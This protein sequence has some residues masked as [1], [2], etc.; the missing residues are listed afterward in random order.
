MMTTMAEKAT[1]IYGTEIPLKHMGKRRQQ[2]QLEANNNSAIANLEQ[3]II[4]KEL[5]ACSS[6]GLAATNQEAQQQQRAAR[7]PTD[8]AAPGA[9]AGSSEQ[10][11]QLS[12]AHKHHRSHHQHRSHHHRHHHHQKHMVAPG[13]QAQAGHHHHHHGRHLRQVPAGQPQPVRTG[14]LQPQRVCPA[15]KQPAEANPQLAAEQMRLQSAGQAEA[16]PL[17]EAAAANLGPKPAEPTA[18]TKASS[19]D[20]G[21]QVA[22]AD[23][24]PANQPALPPRPQKPQQDALNN[25]AELDEPKITALAGQPEAR[26]DAPQLAILV[27]KQPA[28]APAAAAP[29]NEGSSPAERLGRAKPEQQNPMPNAAQESLVNLERLD[30]PPKSGNEEAQVAGSSISKKSMVSNEANPGQIINNNNSS[31][32]VI[33]SSSSHS[34]SSGSFSS[35]EDVSQLEMPPADAPPGEPKASGEQPLDADRTPPSSVV[36]SAPAKPALAVAT[37]TLSTESSDSTEHEATLNK[38]QQKPNTSVITVPSKVTAADVNVTPT[39][40]R[41][42]LAVSLENVSEQQEVLR[43][44]S[45]RITSDNKQR[46]QDLVAQYEKLN[47]TART[48]SSST[49]E[50]NG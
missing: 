42:K 6:G 3:K 10:Q 23:S 5:Q 31:N 38:K 43:D 4:Q 8:S 32:S 47:V 26:A 36:K 40:E 50:E 16:A 46:E 48:S 24:A 2:L 15:A 18:T 39:Q 27:A 7:Q 25:S 45:K 11:Q 14:P 49:E 21:E 41:I 44:P 33:S 19:R 1:K 13:S 35:S 29:A 9:Q 20:N 17:V 30:R 37:K 34:S 28:S 22:A 12:G